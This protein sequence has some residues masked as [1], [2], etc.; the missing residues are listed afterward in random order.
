MRL[1]VGRFGVLAYR[2]LKDLLNFRAFQFGFGFSCT[3]SRRCV[4]RAMP[5]TWLCLSKAF[6]RIAPGADSCSTA[7]QHALPDRP[8]GLGLLLLRY[9][10]LCSLGLWICKRGNEL[11]SGKPPLSHFGEKPPGQQCPTTFRCINLNPKPDR[12]GSG[13]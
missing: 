5:S 10:A 13:Q 4:C 12:L 2:G 11:E 8:A 6:K 1:R 3:V 7:F 9:G